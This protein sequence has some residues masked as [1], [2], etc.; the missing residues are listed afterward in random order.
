[1]IVYQLNKILWDCKE[2]QCES[3]P[4]FCFVH[5]LWPCTMHRPRPCV[6]FPGSLED[7]L[8]TSQSPGWTWNSF[9][10]LSSALCLSLSAFLQAGFLWNDPR[11]RPPLTCLCL[12]VVPMSSSHLC[13]KDSSLWWVR[14][15]PL[16]E[17]TLPARATLRSFYLLSRTA[18]FLLLPDA[19]T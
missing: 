2:E 8:Y 11:G 5:C 3:L 16:A 13:L 14:P 15:H 10:A 4:G 12:L 7:M 9:W 1:M 18:L 17:D 19:H 6:F